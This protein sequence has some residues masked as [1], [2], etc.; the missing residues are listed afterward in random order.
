MK[1][2]DDKK[3]GFA[4]KAIHLGYD[5]ADHEGAVSPPIFMTSTYAFESTADF[6]AVFTGESDRCVY[7]RQQNPTQRLLEK[8]LAALEGGE[9]AIVTASGMGAIASTLLTLLS[10]GDE[11]VVHHTIYNTAGALMDEGLPKFGIKVIRADLSTEEGTQAAITANTKIV[12]FETPINP[13][14]EVLDIQRISKAAKRVGATVIVDSTFASPALQRPIEHGADLVIHSLT[15]YLNGHGDILGGTVIGPRAVMDSIR[16]SGTKFLTGATPSP[17]SCYLVLRG[18]KTLS[19]RMAQH[20]SN[21]L[22]VATM[23][24][25]HPAITKVTYPFLPSF[26]N[27]AIVERQMSSG[28]GMVSFELKTGFAGVAPMIDKLKIIS[29]GISLGDTDS[30]IYHTAGMIEARRK[31]S[32][33]IRLSAGVTPELVRLSVGLEDINDLLEDLEQALS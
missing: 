18:L 30:L 33:H 6:E 5:P 13:S 17:M 7:G 14:S 16:T 2:F 19:L 15:K 25:S 1:E 23:L 9:D 11:I 12:Y 28:S 29:R 21:A 32:P 10:N 24:E 20:S 4:T 22:A 26:A 8:R 31:V 27:R 3:I